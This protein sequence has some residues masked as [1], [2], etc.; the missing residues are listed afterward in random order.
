MAT[1]LWLNVLQ[2]SISV[3]QLTVVDTQPRISD[4]VGASLDGADVHDDD[5][6]V[7]TVVVLV[8]VVDVVGGVQSLSV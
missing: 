6:V 5:V 1:F 7:L 8:V 3:V 2:L 4:T